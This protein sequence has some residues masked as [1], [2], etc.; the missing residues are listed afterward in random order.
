MAETT[1][2]L[3]VDDSPLMRSEIAR[4]LAAGGH[5]VAEAASGM[6]ACARAAREPFDL[7]TLDIEMPGLSG[8]ETLR[9]LKS[10]APDLPVVMISSL[11]SLARAIEA[12]RLGAYDYVSKP[13]DPEDLAL[14]VRRALAQSALTRENRRLVTELR[15][16]NEDL[17]R[18]VDD[19]T[20]E[21]ER[22]H[23][24]LREEHQRLE[25]AYARLRD[26]DDLKTKFVAV[27]SHELRTPL[28]I[29]TGLVDGL[30]SDRLEASRRARVLEAVQRSLDRLA[31]LV[32][33]ITDVAHLSATSVRYHRTPVALA[34]IVGAVA[35][36]LAPLFE[37]RRL[38]FASALPADLPP[39]LVDARRVGQVLSS[40]L[41]NAVRF[42]PDGGSV[43][44]D[45]LPPPDGGR[46]LT[47]RV[48]DTGIGIPREELERIF[49][50]FYEIAPADRHHSGT[51]QFGSSGLGL[52]L[53]IARRIVEG[54]GGSIRAQSG[55]DRGE[56]GSTFIFTLPV[57]EPAG[58][59]S[60][61]AAAPAAAGKAP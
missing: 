61:A 27:T 36:E 8:F 14:C 21:V 19:R 20:A 2:I 16:L 55:L 58:A 46:L 7:V 12:I 28:A 42:T 10:R 29:I 56:P 50:P 53:A 17:G 38:A 4:I 43:T 44:V 57:G 3:V 30:G 54:H 22:A 35:E 33:R 49:E 34:A 51:G 32:A 59:Q 18:L 25:A 45:A 31:E 37:Q 6:E 60:A 39:A 48:R 41:L 13:V 47:V 5:A 40:L 23:A 52:G 11:S 1:R 24:E 15:S 9:I 26:L